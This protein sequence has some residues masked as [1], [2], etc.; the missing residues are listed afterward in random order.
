MRQEVGRWPLF[1]SRLIPGMCYL[2]Q[3]H[4]VNVSLNSFLTRCI[5]VWW[6]E[7]LKS[8]FNIIKSLYLYKNKKLEHTCSSWHRTVLDPTRAVSGSVSRY[9]MVKHVPRALYSMFRTKRQG[10]AQVNMGRHSKSYIYMKLIWGYCIQSF[11][12]CQSFQK[13][14]IQL[15]NT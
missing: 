8:L 11:C 10:I 1:H 15:F 5:G 14:C 12:C 3:C 6:W 2:Q 4:S 13:P 7:I 9:C